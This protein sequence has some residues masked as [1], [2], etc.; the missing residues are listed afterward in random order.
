[1]KLN[2]VP[3]YVSK[4]RQGRTYIF[5]AVLIAAL[6][7]ASSVLMILSSQSKLREAKA[8]NER[9]KP[10][11]QAAVDTSAQA[12]TIISDS[13]LIIKDTNLATEM[14][15]HNDVYPDF[16]TREIIPYIPPFY[17][18]NSLTATPAD[19]TTSTVTMVGTLTTYQQYTDL[20][21]ALMRIKGAVSVSRA[22]F[23]GERFMVPGITPNNQHPKSLKVGQAPEPDDP[24]ERLTYLQSQGT[25]DPGYTGAGNFG[26]GNEEQRGAT[27]T[28]SLVTIVLTI[29]KNLQ[30]PNP[31]ATLS[32]GGGGAAP[33]GGLA[34]GGFGSPGGPPPGFGG[35]P[36][37]AGGVP[38][39]V[40]RGK[41]AGDD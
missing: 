2:L 20:V 41:G 28:E 37:G 16:Y 21:L 18:I 39:A 1:M 24:I 33:A 25:G 7:I 8:A 4:E 40:G 10:G 6:G 5:F 29:K 15:K 9:A 35:P 22:G 36:S 26:S 31:R 30:T 38:P 23:S 19:A 32:S 13:A 11:A 34:G 27:P 12:D 3:T 17:R 14:I